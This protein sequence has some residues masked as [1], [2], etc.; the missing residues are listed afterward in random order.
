MSRRAAGRAASLALGVATLVLTAAA[1]A[2]DA[3]VRDSWMRLLLPS[4]PAAG[5][6]ELDNH[7][8][9]TLTLTGAASPGCGSL[10]LHRSVHNGGTE[11]MDAISQVAV[12]AH[13]TIRF[14]PGGY[15]LMCVQPAQG[16]HPGGTMPVTLTFAG[17]GELTTNFTIE[18]PR[19]R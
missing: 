5:Y 3:S 18:G 6:F 14:A 2:P 16:L 11:R 8:A 10:M 9:S 13:G 12:P 19:G 1:P 15:H 17:G 4:R 7:G